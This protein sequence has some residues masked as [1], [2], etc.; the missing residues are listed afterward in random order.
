MA[1]P[2]FDTASQTLRLEDVDFV[3][4]AVD[5]DLGLMANLFYDRI[6]TRI[7]TAANNMLAERNKAIQDTLSDTLAAD[8]PPNLAPDL[9]NLR[10]AELRF[11]V[12]DA[13]LTVTGTADG[14]L[15]LGGSRFSRRP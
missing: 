7:E 13:G 12:G 14:V 10:I 4:D 6:R 2:G 8:L 1:R 15:K 3:F 9:S 5:P 11:R